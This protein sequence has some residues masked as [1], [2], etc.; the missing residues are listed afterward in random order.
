MNIRQGSNSWGDIILNVD[1]DKVR[2]GSNSW[3]EV[4]MVAVATPFVG[5]QFWGEVI[6]NV[7]GDQIRERLKLLGNG[8][9]QCGW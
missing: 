2:R 1:G 7:D 8:D 9:R 4:I 3:G 6:A 5:D